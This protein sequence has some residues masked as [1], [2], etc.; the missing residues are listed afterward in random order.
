MSLAD[1]LSDVGFGIGW[2]AIRRLPEP[3]VDRGFRA[4]ADRTYRKEGPGVHQ[5]RSNLARVLD[6][7]ALGSLEDVTRENLRL[8]MRYWSEVFCLPGWDSA[9]LRDS[10]NLR[11]GV[12]LLDD[13]VNA[14]RGAIMVA[15]HSGNW[16]LAGAWACDRYGSITTVAE[17]VKPEALFDKF[18]SYRQSLGMEVLPLGGSDTL[19]TLVRRLREG[20]LVC[21]VADRDISGTGV[22]VDFFGEKASI[23]AGPATMSLM[24]GAPIMPVRL[25]HTSDGLQ[26]RVDPGLPS[27]T[28]ADRA[29]RVLE[30]TQSMADALADSI[31]EHPADWHM[32]Q[33]LWLSDLP[34][35]PV[36]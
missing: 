16:D 13:A 33:R 36:S 17:Q 14:G 11:S 18:V 32:L 4:I 35:R 28:S 30:L 29:E 31:R 34:T 15:S 24:T 6:E 20:Q 7:E 9:R 19:R 22:P 12:D 1:T 23:P 5:L 2:S 27:P 26:A 3:V 21:L 10:F 8:Y 25:W